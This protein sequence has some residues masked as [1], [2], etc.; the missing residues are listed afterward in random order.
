[1]AFVLSLFLQSIFN[2]LV[3]LLPRWRLNSNASVLVNRDVAT[4]CLTSDIITVSLK[5][6][7]RL[8]AA[9]KAK[10]SV[11]LFRLGV[12]NCACQEKQSN[13]GMILSFMAGR[14]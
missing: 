6:S 3:Y 1:V 10:Q 14:F 9:H 4:N 5:N 11:F 7:F 8:P 2:Q 12:N 13:A